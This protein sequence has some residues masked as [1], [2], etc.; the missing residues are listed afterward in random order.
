[1]MA[2]LPDTQEIP[3]ITV[4]APN[5]NPNPKDTT[6]PG[7]STDHQEASHAGGNEIGR[8]VVK[9]LDLKTV[10]LIIGVIVGWAGSYF[11]TSARLDDYGRRISVNEQKIGD[12]VPRSEQLLRDQNLSQRLGNIELTLRDIQLRQIREVERR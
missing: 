3:V 12:M 10:I 11:T 6:L 1:M 4:P 9:Q 2:V 8:W 7:E 5:I